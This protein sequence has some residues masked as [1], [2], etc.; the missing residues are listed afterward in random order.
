MGVGVEERETCS[1][2]VASV[3]EVGAGD[4]QEL[5][6][7]LLPRIWF[8]EIELVGRSRWRRIQRNDR[9]FSGTTAIIETRTSTEG[10]FI[11][12]VSS[13]IRSVRELNALSLL[14]LVSVLFVY[15]STDP[16]THRRHEPIEAWLQRHRI[17]YP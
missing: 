12:A 4:R 6:S 10:R 3:E 1:K 14:V 17:A 11:P 15:G 16:Q 7:N 9:C 2:G 5:D 8:S 13:E